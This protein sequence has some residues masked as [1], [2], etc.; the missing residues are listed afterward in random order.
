ML[1]GMRLPDGDI[2]WHARYFLQPQE[3]LEFVR[4]KCP[5][6]DLSEEGTSFQTLFCEPYPKIYNESLAVFVVWNPD[7]PEPDINKSFGSREEALASAPDGSIVVDVPK[8]ELS[9][10][11]IPWHLFSST[12]KGEVEVETT[13]S[14]VDLSEDSAVNVVEVSASS[15][16]ENEVSNIEPEKVLWQFN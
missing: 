7:E 11:P 1:E 3:R 10:S 8:S 14:V 13:D 15:L 6:L 12:L 4:R 5:H 2:L 16:S 9:S